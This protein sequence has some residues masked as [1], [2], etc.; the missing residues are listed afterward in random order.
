MISSTW[1]LWVA[2]NLIFQCTNA[3]VKFFY[4]A[5]NVVLGNRPVRNAPAA[6]SDGRMSTNGPCGGAEQ[7]G[8]NG[9][10]AIAQ[11][12]TLNMKINYNGG[13]RA[14]EN[15]FKAL[16]LC[17]SPTQSEIAA[18][19]P[20][21]GGNEF[22]PTPNHFEM[23]CNGNG[24]TGACEVECPTPTADQRAQGM[25][26][27]ATQGNQVTE[28]YVMKCTIPS[29]M[30]GQCTVSIS[31]QRKW[32]GCYDLNVQ[33]R[34]PAPTIGGVA[35]TGDDPIR[36]NEGRYFYEKSAEIQTAEAGKSCCSLEYGEFTVYENRAT[37][38][39]M[40]GVSTEG[41]CPVDG[42][43][44]SF[45][46][47]ML[48]NLYKDQNGDTYRGKISRLGPKEGQDFEISVS[49][50]VLS[51]S[52]VDPNAPQICDGAFKRRSLDSAYPSSALAKFPNFVL[53]LLCI[54]GFLLY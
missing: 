5:N 27:P 35:V 1:T 2:A 17:G 15:N 53:G 47:F 18:V 45:S 20:N 50:G 3:H 31:D 14:P 49:E 30:I 34:T 48:A 12:D 10:S 24:C 37:F 42:R 22:T 21:G 19:I 13:H 44:E 25:Y 4:S 43:M 6:A 52:N 54:F 36:R 29:E 32:G 9:V 40:V 33:E 23:T 51:L 41:A 38:S 8:A 26:C 11:G 16:W 28:G 7:W 39:M 46:K